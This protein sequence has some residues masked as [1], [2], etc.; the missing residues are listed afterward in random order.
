MPRVRSILETCLYVDDLDRARSFY[1]DLFE[2]PVIIRDDRFCA[3]AVSRDDVLLLFRRGASAQALQIPW[4]VMPAHDSR[5]PAHFAFGIESDDVE[6]WRERLAQFGVAIE[7]EVH[8]PLGGTSFYFRD[9]DGHAVELAT[10]GIWDFSVL[11]GP[12]E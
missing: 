7:S 10:P 11:D 6:P 3:L 2:L 4:G 9:P 1:T 8:W 5:G 12:E